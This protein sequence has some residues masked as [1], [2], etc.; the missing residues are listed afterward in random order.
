MQVGSSPRGHGPTPLKSHGSR[1][2]VQRRTGRSVEGA[3]MD[4]C[5]NG[6]VSKPLNCTTALKVTQL[7]RPLLIWCICISISL[8]KS[9][10]NSVNASKF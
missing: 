8:Q 1:S 2:W 10:Q 4:G 7:E 6:D 5:K 9:G 3:K